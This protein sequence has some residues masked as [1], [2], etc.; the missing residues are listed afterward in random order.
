[1]KFFTFTFLIVMLF[2]SL[3][4][5]NDQY[6]PVSTQSLQ[7]IDGKMLMIISYVIVLVLLMGYWIKMAWQSKQIRNKLKQIN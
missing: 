1:M 6:V 3:A 4:F 2:Y 5:A 7:T